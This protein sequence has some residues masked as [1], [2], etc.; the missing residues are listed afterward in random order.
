LSTEDERQRSS[1]IDLSPLATPNPKKRKIAPEV[2]KVKYRPNSSSSGPP[3]SPLKPTGKRKLSP[4][5]DDLEMMTIPTS[6]V[7]ENELDTSA[8]L[9]DTRR[10]YKDFNT[11]FGT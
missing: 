1:P 3:S 5:Y 11:H 4:E 10:K 2:R 7:D 6:D 8:N 9:N